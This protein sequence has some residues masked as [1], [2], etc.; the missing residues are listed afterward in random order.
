MS[1]MNHIDLYHMLSSMSVKS[2]SRTRD[3][4]E[5]LIKNKTPADRQHI[6]SLNA[7]NYVKYIP[8][9]CSDSHCKQLM[10]ELKLV[11]NTD[12]LKSQSPKSAWFTNTEL[13]YSWESHTTGNV[14][15]KQPNP[16]GE[17]SAMNAMLIR[18]NKMLGSSMNSCLVQ[19]YPSGHSGIRLHDDLEPEMAGDDHIAVVSIG[20]SRTIEFL[21]N[22]K[23]PSEDACLSIKPS[24]SSLYVMLAGCQDYY[25]H[26]VPSDASCNGWR[27]SFSF[28]KVVGVTSQDLPSK[29]TTPSQVI[30]NEIG[31]LLLDCSFNSEERVPRHTVKSM[32]APTTAASVGDTS[33]RPSGSASLDIC[34]PYH[35][36]EHVTTP[37]APDKKISLLLGTSITKWVKSDRLSDDTTDFINISHSGA[38][39][40]NTRPGERIPDFGEM[41]DNFAAAN[42]EK[43]PHVKQ[44]IISLGTNDIK[45]YRTDNGRNVKATPGDI[46]VFYSP[47]VHLIHSARYHFGSNVQI[48]LQSVL[49]MRLLYTYTGINFLNFNRLL[50]HICREFNCHYLNYFDMFLDDQGYDHN[51]ALFSDTIHLNHRGYDLLHK[52][53]KYTV[54]GY[55]DWKIK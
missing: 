49:P 10:D 13:N 4:I 32:G 17:N 20:A 14:T 6:V 25:R 44:L 1:T 24:N 2:L 41:L 37:P 40:S 11:L 7:N 53:L 52:C 50:K 27:A 34:D 28:R 43:V 47:I 5:N 48:C 18:I 33:A 29:N 21:H 51:R 46:T 3:Y 15:T 54:D 16:I 9:F 35:S 36:G 30:T 42:R 12:S 22:Y 8:G 23:A 55:R 31:T 38:K 45:H 19:F 26:R 39:I